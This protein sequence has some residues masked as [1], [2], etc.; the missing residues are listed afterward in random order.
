MNAGNVEEMKAGMK[1]MDLVINAVL[2][3]FFLKIMKAAL[4]SGTHYLDMATDLAVAAHEKPGDKI[5]K[6]PIDLQLEQDED[7]KKA[8]L[9]AMLCWG[10]DPGA[11]NVYA[12]Y[13]ADGMDSVEKILV[14]DGDS[15]YIEGFDGFAALWSPDTLIEE[16]ALMNA[17]VWTDGHFERLPSLGV[18]EV[19]EFPPPLGKMRVWAVDHE[20]PE[21]LGRTIGKGCKECNFMIVLGEETAEILD[22]LRKLGMVRPEPIDVKGVKVSP[23]DVVT[24]LMP[25]PNDPEIQKNV[26]GTAIVGTVVIGKKNGKKIS[27]YVY[28]K[29][30]HAECYRKYGI[31]AV[32]WQT[33]APAAIAAIM[34]ARGEI[35]K[36]GV[37]TPE[38]LEPK[39][40]LERFKEFGFRWNEEIKEL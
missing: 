38:L 30:D 6:V 19:F 20:E 17:L 8:D 16:V 23:R 11:C 13:A 24:A 3:R 27:H 39:P 31:T 21:T 18:S 29:A 7:W 32:A 40:I 15:G 33:A 35:A 2:P 5:D 14:R 12:R 28:Q 25:S 22:V 34:L 37:F 1:G 36:K 9:S 4:E 10:N 26:R